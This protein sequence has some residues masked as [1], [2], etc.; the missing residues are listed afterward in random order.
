MDRVWTHCVGWKI[1]CFEEGGG[2]AR[3]GGLLIFISISISIFIFIF[4]FVLLLPP[5]LLPL[6]PQLLDLL[7]EALPLVPS[8]IVL[9][10]GEQLD[11]VLDR[12]LGI[13][14][15]L[16][17]IRVSSVEEAPR[18][19]TH[20]ARGHHLGAKPGSLHGHERGVSAQP[21]F[22][23]RKVGSGAEVATGGA[24]AGGARLDARFGLVAVG[25]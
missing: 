5:L 15:E 25:A 8:H 11:G 4:T 12:T 6:L 2:Y 21:V 10:L 20:V 1:V 18:L 7:S 22:V 16:E 14:G 9:Y 17:V 13:V 23:R 3:E 24:I 19:P